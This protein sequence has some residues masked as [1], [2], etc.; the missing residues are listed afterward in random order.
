MPTLTL[1]LAFLTTV[2]TSPQ[3]VPAAYLTS[4]IR[5]SLPARRERCSRLLTPRRA[6]LSGVGPS[7]CSASG[8]WPYTSESSTAL[9]RWTSLLPPSELVFVSAHTAIRLS[10]EP[11]KSRADRKY[12]V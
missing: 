3:S 9:E 12:S 7:F 11:L 5:S 8:G 6:S 10:S 4:F 2:L 1:P